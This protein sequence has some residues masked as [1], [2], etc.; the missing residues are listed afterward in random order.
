MVIQSRHKPPGF[1]MPTIYGF[2]F[3]ETLHLDCHLQLTSND[4]FCFD[5][6]W[7]KQQMEIIL[8]LSA[9]RHLVIAYFCQYI[10]NLHIKIRVKRGLNVCIYHII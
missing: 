8:I 10:F 1:N 5:S 4:L 3:Y 7:I 9:Y 6:L 2:D